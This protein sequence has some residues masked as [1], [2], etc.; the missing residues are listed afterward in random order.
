MGRSCFKLFSTGIQFRVTNQHKHFKLGKLA[1]EILSKQPHQKRAGGTKYL[2][3]SSQK[4]QNKRQV[5]KKVRITQ[6]RI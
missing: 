2:P 5:K 1:M 4:N 6:T 3:Y